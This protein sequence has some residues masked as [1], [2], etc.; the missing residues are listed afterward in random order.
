MGVVKVK[1]LVVMSGEKLP[2]QNTGT[3]QSIGLIH[4]KGVATVYTI[5]PVNTDYELL[6]EY[7]NVPQS[8]H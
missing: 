6:G 1:E 5:S 2:S 4:V 8:T 3:E 7:K